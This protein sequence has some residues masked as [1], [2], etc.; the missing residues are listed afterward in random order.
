MDS[1]TKLN[2]LG[3]FEQQVVVILA[4][5]S[6]YFDNNDPISQMDIEMNYT[7]RYTLI[8]N[9][10]DPLSESSFETIVTADVTWF[11]D[12]VYLGSRN[13]TET[14]DI[15]TSVDIGDIETI[16][17]DIGTYEAAALTISQG[18]TVRK[19]WLAKG[20]GIIKLE[21]NTFD[22]PLTATLYDTNILTFSEDSQAKSISKSPHYGG[23]HLQKVFKSPPDT[24]ERMLELCRFLRE[25]CPR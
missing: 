15:V 12:Q 21:Y 18:E 20:I 4:V 7:P 10:I 13:F 1:Q 19:W 8:R 16:E 6:I 24:P 14:V 17:T 25:L 22:F 23:N 9:H 11:F 5:I 2:L 3:F